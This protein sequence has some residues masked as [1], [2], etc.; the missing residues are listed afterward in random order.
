M[1]RDD[2][3]HYVRYVFD[4]RRLHMYPDKCPTTKGSML[5]AIRVLLVIHYHDQ[6]KAKM[7]I[8]MR[9]M[10]YPDSFRA[11]YRS[12]FSDYLILVHVQLQQCAYRFM[13]TDVIHYEN[14]FPLIFRL[15]EHGQELRL[16]CIQ[17]EAIR[18]SKPHKFQQ[19]RVFL[20]RM[21]KFLKSSMNRIMTI[22]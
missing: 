10:S 11:V 14:Y 20:N 15:L 5:M 8:F 17:I 21:Y 16:H 18:A 13:K 7:S 12:P 19:S 6:L 22:V 9:I 3:L 1:P 2:M 4:A